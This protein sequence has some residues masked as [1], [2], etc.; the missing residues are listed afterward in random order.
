M[1]IPNGILSSMILTLCHGT[2]DKNERT[3]RVEYFHLCSLAIAINEFHFE[4]IW[5]TWAIHQQ[6][7]LSLTI[8]LIGHAKD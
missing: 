7:Q 6:K 3:T 8:S 1:L 5:K 2:K 4:E